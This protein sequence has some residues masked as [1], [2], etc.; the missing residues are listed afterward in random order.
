MVE[1][2]TVAAIE[3]AQASY[4]MGDLRTKLARWHAHVDVAFRGW[5]DAWLDPKFREWDIAGFLPTVA[6]PAQIIQ[7]DRDPYG[8]ERQIAIARQALPAP[9]L[10]AL[11]PGV[12][13]APHKEA[14]EATLTRIRDFA[15]C[16]F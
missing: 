11:L 13:H 4:E 3:R 6:A 2:M 5:C 10:V 16:L 8:S 15:L 1:D 9:P 12:G 14:P 7:G